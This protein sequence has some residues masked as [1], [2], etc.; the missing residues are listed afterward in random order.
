MSSL[1]LHSPQDE[2]ERDAWLENPTERESWAALGQLIEAGVPAFDE[3]RLLAE[4]LRRVSPAT[5]ALDASSPGLQRSSPPWFALAASVALLVMA[6]WGAIRS[7]D[8][9]SPLSLTGSLSSTQPQIATH[10]TSPSAAVNSVVATD[11]AWEQDESFTAEISAV[12]E[13]IVLFEERMRITPT[14]VAVIAEW[15]DDLR[16]DIE[17]QDL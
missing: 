3:Q 5:R 11:I 10:P 17:E 16:R 4:V 9:L 7:S 6:G 13:T 8:Y 1:R 2:P 12:E 15:I 14:E